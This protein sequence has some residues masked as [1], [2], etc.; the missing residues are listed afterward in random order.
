MT[1]WIDMSIVAYI[2]SITLIMIIIIN[3]LILWRLLCW[4]RC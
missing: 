3:I 2:Q 4:W 1:W